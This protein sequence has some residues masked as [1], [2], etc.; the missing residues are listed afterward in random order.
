MRRCWRSRKRPPRRPSVQEKG[1]RKGKRLTDDNHPQT[2][3]SAYLDRVEGGR[4]V[5]IAG[6][7]GEIQLDLPLDRLPQGAKAGDH[8]IISIGLD[9]E[10]TETAR[11]RIT[12]LQQEL[13]Q[14]SGPHTTEFKL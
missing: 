4:A 10:S 6:D 2:S 1:R 13:K 14:S 11:E 8:L 9:P 12:E 3:F 5:V 7:D